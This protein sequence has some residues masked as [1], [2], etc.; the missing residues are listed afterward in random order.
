MSLVGILDSLVILV[1][2]LNYWV[3]TC[4]ENLEI[5][6]NLTAVRNFTKNQGNVRGKILSGKLFIVTAYLN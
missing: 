3:T 1:I 2:R 5:S 4:L 6:G